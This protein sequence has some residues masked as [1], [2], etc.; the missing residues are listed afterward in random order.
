MGNLYHLFTSEL[1]GGSGAK[2]SQASLLSLSVL[3]LHV[4]YIDFCPPLQKCTINQYSNKSSFL[5]EK[6]SFQLSGHEVWVLSVLHLTLGLIC[7]TTG[8]WAS[9][10][11]VTGGLT[12]SAQCKYSSWS[13]AETIFLLRERKNRYN[14]NLLYFLNYL[15]VETE[16]PSHHFCFISILNWT[17]T[18]S[19]AIVNRCVVACL[20]IYLFVCFI[21]LNLL[22]VLA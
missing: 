14:K 6:R 22:L 1:W 9:S 16:Q 18:R 3:R 11:S 21:S 13:W 15:V 20:F 19:V 17:C 10:A 12:L 8:T 2:V 4:A 7:P 5:L